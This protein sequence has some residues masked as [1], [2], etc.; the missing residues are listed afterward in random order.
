[1]SQKT[2]T[3]QMN[4][5]GLF[6]MNDKYFMKLMNEVLVQEDKMKKNRN[7]KMYVLKISVPNNYFEKITGYKFANK[8]CII[9]STY[10][11]MILECIKNKIMNYAFIKELYYLYEDNAEH[12]YDEKDFN[13]ESAI[14][15]IGKVK[16]WFEKL[17]H[18]DGET[19]E[20]FEN[21][22]M[23]AFAFSKFIIWVENYLKTDKHYLQITEGEF[24]NIIVRDE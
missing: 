16:V 9:S 13:E 18:P 10:P 21:R 15:F 2:E 24:T 19:N 6:I 7:K 8:T 3:E 1:M 23:L 20:M 4:E 22:V 11:G 5:D 17:D 12:E 14:E